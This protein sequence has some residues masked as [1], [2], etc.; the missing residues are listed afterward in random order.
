VT[1]TAAPSMDIQVS[2]NFERLLFDLHGRDGAALGAAMTSFEANRSVALTPAMRTGAEALFSSARIDA[3]TMTLAMRRASETAAMLLDPHTAIGVAAAYA[4]ELPKEV[5][6]V[7]LATAHPA[8][9]PD[10][11][12]RATGMRPPLP[13]RVGDLFDRAE[14]Y[15]VLPAD[16]GAVQAYVAERATA[17]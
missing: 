6:V 3:E 1:P 5:P 7:T 15:D 17:T 9:F 14:R 12:E 10:A 4:A 16:L 11:V 8:K 13:R 2:S